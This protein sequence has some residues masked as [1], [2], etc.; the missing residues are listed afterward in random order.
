MLFK[1]NSKKADAKVYSRIVSYTGAY[2]DQRM[3]ARAGWYFKMYRISFNRFDEDAISWLFYSMDA[4]VQLI[5]NGD[6]CYALIGYKADRPASVTGDFTITD[7]RVGADP[8]PVD[9]WYEM[10][11]ERLRFEPYEKKDG[12]TCISAVQPWG[13]KLL[14]GEVRISG[15][16]SRT[17]TLTNIPA[18]I[19]PAFGSELLR[20][21]P[22]ITLSAHVK[23]EDPEAMLDALIRDKDIVPAR[24]S[25]MREFLE[26]VVDS[27]EAVYNTSVLVNITS[28][29]GYIDEIC[30]RFAAFCAQYYITPSAMDFLQLRALQATLPLLDDSVKYT[31][32][33]TQDQLFALLPWSVLRDVKKNV[34]YGRDAVVGDICYDRRALHE[35][36]IIVSTDP[37][38]MEKTALSEAEQYGK[39]LGGDNV[40][41]VS[42]DPDLI[43]KL[44][45]KPAGSAETDFERLPADLRIKCLARWATDCYE[46]NGAISRAKLDI[47]KKAADACDKNAPDLVDEYVSK[48][49]E[50]DRHSLNKDR[51]PAKFRADVYTGEYC[52]L[53]IPEKTG[54]AAQD[55]MAYAVTLASGTGIVYAMDAENLCWAAA[56]PFDPA[57]DTLYTLCP[58]DVRRFYDSE[59]MSRFVKESAFIFAGE[60]KVAEK[61]RL[62]SLAGLSRSQRDLISD[63]AKGVVL[64]TDLCC[65]Q[66]G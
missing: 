65:Y 47:V 42:T 5:A 17:Y 48:I 23:R 8:L 41:I 18:Q 1:K 60:H 12:A 63:P 50:K 28:D 59:Y 64:I 57:D 32:L 33:L 62:T 44:G 36:G 16:V 21:D 7:C 20:I 13:F 38:W 61:L 24:K 56:D 22:G 9:D 51:I 45:V 30:G 11:S 15:K 6:D 14:P 3:I 26:A 55:E 34:Y 37:A 25:V 29:E 53:V 49:P 35:N 43:G 4:H 2:P 66:L 52:T 39:M 10:L 40:Y 58:A 19:F 46:V 54:N 31:R 27:N